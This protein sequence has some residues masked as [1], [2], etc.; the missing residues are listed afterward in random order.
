MY[1]SI[2]VALAVLALAG[3]GAS[4]P[5]QVPDAGVDASTPQISA[6]VSPARARVVAPAKTTKRA[7]RPAAPAPAPATRR[8]VPAQPVAEPAARKPPAAPA[9]AVEAPKPRTVEPTP[10]APPAKPTPKPAPVKLPPCY[11]T[12]LF[13]GSGDAAPQGDCEGTPAVIDCRKPGNP[14]LQCTGIHPTPGAPPA[15]DAPTMKRY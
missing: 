8:A 10:A 5:V 1:R 13:P 3:C 12:I 4:E 11:T 2:T 6:T 9:P 15:Y 7:A 14:H